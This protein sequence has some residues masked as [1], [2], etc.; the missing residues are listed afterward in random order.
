[1][2]NES[3]LNLQQHLQF[4]W[5]EPYKRQFLDSFV[6]VFRSMT[7]SLNN[8]DKSI[9]D[10][11]LRF[12]SIM[13]NA[14]HHMRTKQYSSANS[15]RE[16][17]QPCWWDSDYDQAKHEKNANLRRYRKTLSETLLADYLAKN[18]TFKNLCMAK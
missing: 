15:N 8:D 16:K 3:E 2:L 18:R 4:N 11:L 14:G 9:I 10:S 5:K 13:Q 17:Q 1:M 12:N 7:D 6:P